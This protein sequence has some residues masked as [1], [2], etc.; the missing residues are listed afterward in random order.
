M[1]FFRP[2]LC[3]IDLSALKFNYRQLKQCAGSREM[4][5]VVKANAYG[6]GAVAISRALENEGAQIFGVATIEEGIELRR[7]GISSPI[8]CFGGSLG[9]HVSDL[10][11]YGL[12]PAVFNEESIQE[13]NRQASSLNQKLAVHLKIDTGMTRLGILPSELKPI[14]QLL[15]QSSALELKGVFTHLAQADELIEKPTEDQIEKFKQ[16]EEVIQSSSFSVPIYHVANSAALIDK[17]LDKTDLVRPG[18]ALYGAYP[19]PRF[20]KKIPLKQVMSLK[21]QVISVKSVPKGTAVSYGATFITKRPSRVAVIPIGYA[22]GYS[23]SFS[24]KGEV[25]IAGRRVPVIG[26]VCMDLTMIDVTDLPASSI[27]DEVVLIGKQGNELIRAEEL[28]QKIGT[29][30]YEIFCSISSR[31]PR[32]TVSKE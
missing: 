22:D 12:T 5:A 14:V 8:L 7:A 29:I 32:L 19:N 2:T 13:L 9:A 28:A 25:L 30:P 23:R 31:I 11:E 4:L 10:L 21:T 6:H 20:E 16:V 26:R 17:K 15:K 18:L 3:E 1:P 24:N 27:G